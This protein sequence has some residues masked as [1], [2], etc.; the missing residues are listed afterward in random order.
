MQLRVL[1]VTDSFLYLVAQNCMCSHTER[2]Q[3]PV[4]GGLPV[5]WIIRQIQKYSYINIS[6][7]SLYT[8]QDT[9]SFPDIRAFTL[10]GRALAILHNKRKNNA[11]HERAA[12]VDV[13]LFPNRRIGES[14]KTRRHLRE[15]GED[16]SCERTKSRP[17]ERR[18]SSQTGKMDDRD[19][20]RYRGDQIGTRTRLPSI[21]TRST[22]RH[23]RRV[24]FV[25][26]F[27]AGGRRKNRKLCTGA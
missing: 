5:I 3:T 17:R 24:L 26:H 11:K 13:Q 27:A 22:R 1:H 14:G 18:F 21:R 8:T 15:R 20:N 25:R 10:R 6:Y 7:H 9:L 23:G 12:F 19:S 2:L 4:N 16:P